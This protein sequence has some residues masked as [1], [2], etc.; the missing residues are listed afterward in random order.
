ME[1]NSLI[2]KTPWIVNKTKRKKTLGNKN[3]LQTKNPKTIFFL[4]KKN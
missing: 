2:N 3:P 1:K 4:K